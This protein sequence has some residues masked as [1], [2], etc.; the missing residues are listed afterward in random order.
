MSPTETPLHQDPT[1]TIPII[2]SDPSPHRNPHYSTIVLPPPAAPTTLHPPDN[3]TSAPAVA[4][5]QPLIL[6]KVLIWL[7]QL[8]SLRNQL[9]SQL[10]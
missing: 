3:T 7:T 2:I 5:P 4:D 10:I 6:I 9:I 1:V 8:W